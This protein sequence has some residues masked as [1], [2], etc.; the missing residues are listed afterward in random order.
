METN[1]V[2]T[3]KELTPKT[4]AKDQ[5][6]TMELITNP[7]PSTIRKLQAYTSG[8]EER[9]NKFAIGICS[10]LMQVNTFDD[11]ETPLKFF[12]QAISTFNK[13]AAEPLLALNILVT[14]MDAM[15]MT[16]EQKLFICTWLCKCMKYNR[17]NDRKL[18]NIRLLMDTYCKKLGAQCQT[19]NNP[20]TKS[21]RD[22]LKEIVNISA[23]KVLDNI[24]HYDSKDSMKILSKFASLV[25]EKEN[26]TY[27]KPR[28][29]P[30]NPLAHYL[31]LQREYMKQSP[32]P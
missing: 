14:N 24:E 27:E 11:V 1:T 12:W 17:I 22:K 18:D 13:Y 31:A 4:S 3:T 7:D 21:I 16:P 23:E 2:S 10:E 29:I 30:D 9:Y 8:R 26:P 19:P 32:N 28:A 20:K 25:I 15:L 5:L 6:P